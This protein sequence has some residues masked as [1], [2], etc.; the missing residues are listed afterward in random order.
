[1]SNLKPP[2]DHHELARRNIDW[3]AHPVDI[4]IAMADGIGLK[5]DPAGEKAMRRICHAPAKLRLSP[6]KKIAVATGTR[7][8]LTVVKR[9]P[10]GNW[11]T[12]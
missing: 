5:L 4:L 12:R 3:S 2:R 10:Q 7:R 8:R 1:M 9:R 11:V 6:R